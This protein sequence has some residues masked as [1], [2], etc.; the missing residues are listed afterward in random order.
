MEDHINTIA[1]AELLEHPPTKRSQDEVTDYS[2]E[3]INTFT[4]AANEST[5]AGKVRRR[6]EKQP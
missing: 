1:T 3:N 4:L 5:L 6:R 2:S